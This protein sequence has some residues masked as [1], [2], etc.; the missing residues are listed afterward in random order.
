MHSFNAEIT[1]KEYKCIQSDSPTCINLILT[2][3]T[4]RLNN[5]VTIETGLS[6]C[7]VMMATALKGSFHKSDPKVLT[8]RDHNPIN[9]LLGQNFW[10]NLNL[11]WRI[12][13]F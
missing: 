10:K 8:Y 4:S 2:S 3:D 1:A 12:S 7:H 9:Q 11:A 6:E 5:T 13:Q